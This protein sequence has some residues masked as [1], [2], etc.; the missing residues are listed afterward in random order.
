MPATRAQK[1]TFANLPRLS[2]DHTIGKYTVVIKFDESVTVFDYNFVDSSI[3]FEKLLE[4]AISGI[5]GDSTILPSL[6]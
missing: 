1:N 2:T 5:S 6:R 3:S 4:I